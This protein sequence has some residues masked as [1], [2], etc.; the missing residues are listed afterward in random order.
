MSNHV[1]RMYGQL[2]PHELDKSP[3]F[4]ELMLMYLWP[5]V[6]AVED[7]QFEQ[8]TPVHVIYDTLLYSTVN[9]RQKKSNKSSGRKC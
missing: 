5:T 7:Q 6:Y 2:Q 4:D 9:R 3:T 1:K 8:T